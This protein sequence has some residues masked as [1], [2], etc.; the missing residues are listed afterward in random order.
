MPEGY[1]VKA[2]LSAEDKNFSSTM[3]KA[4][5]G[6]D[7][8]TGKLTKGLGFGVLAGIGQQAFSTI[9]SAAGSFISELP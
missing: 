6:L 1:S 7:S 5:S 9:P 4:A 8:L 2:I 3:S